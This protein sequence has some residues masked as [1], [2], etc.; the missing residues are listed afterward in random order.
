MIEQSS[1]AIMFATGPNS[2]VFLATV[3][4]EVTES[5][6]DIIRTCINISIIVYAHCSYAISAIKIKIN[7][8]SDII[9]NGIMRDGIVVTSNTTSGY[10]IA[11]HN[12]RSV[13][14]VDKVFLYK[15]IDIIFCNNA[16]ADQ[17]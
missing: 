17:T 1:D 7:A 10:V 5:R 2:E 12:S 11:E 8:Q 6:E 14:I 15:V 9:I 16:R 13:I 4:V 3:A